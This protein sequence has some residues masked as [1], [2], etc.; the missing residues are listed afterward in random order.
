[1]YMEIKISDFILEAEDFFSLEQCNELIKY[2]ET[3]SD[4]GFAHTRSKYIKDS[5]KVSDK[6]VFISDCATI[7]L[8]NNEI[9]SYFNS[10]FWENIYTEYLN[11]YGILNSY[12]SHKIHHV[13]L[14][15]TQPGGEGYHVWHCEGG[16]IANSSRIMFFILY[17]NDVDLGGETEFLYLSRR[18]LPKVGKLILAPSQFT[19][20]HRGNPPLSNDK[21]ILTGWVEFD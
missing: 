18:I 17:L 6:Q 4:L 20:T 2:Y 13:K 11:K 8:A 5:L 1:M 21:Y 10:I 19:H 3:M 9:V 7:K 12:A 16:D 15:K 14:Q